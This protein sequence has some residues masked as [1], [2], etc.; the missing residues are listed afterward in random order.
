MNKNI[1]EIQGLFERHFMRSKNSSMSIGV[2]KGTEIF[3]YNLSK[4]DTKPVEL[5]GL[6][7]VSKTIIATYLAKMEKEKKISFNDRVSDYLSLNP[8]IKYPTI[9]QLASHTSGYHAF[10]P[11][12]QSIKILIL[13]G[14][15]KK[16]I[17]MNLDQKWLVKDLNHRKALRCKKYRYSDYNYAVLALVIEKIEGKPYKDVIE[18]FLHEEL[19]MTNTIYG[20][21]ALTK[22]FKYSWFWEDDNPFL[23]SGGLFSTVDDMML[24]L[25][26]QIDHCDYLYKAHKKYVRI[27]KKKNIF[28]AFSWNA[29][30]TG[31]FYWHIGGQGHYRSYVLFDIKREI[32]ITLLSTVDI[33]LI[34]VG[35][36]GSSLYRNIKRN[37][38]VVTEYLDEM[39]EK[40]G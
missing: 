15:N 19:G 38:K 31:N 25:R 1:E 34:H 22:D 13:R 37:H 39:I 4:N 24:F 7:S 8:K 18:T 5:Y 11:V 21:K 27:N 2:S 26:Y 14:F 10:I 35:R 16:N 6:G 32:T 29:F 12:L 3:K 33:D 20:S 9:L 30:Y 23:A 17:Y 40:Q 28:S 36:I